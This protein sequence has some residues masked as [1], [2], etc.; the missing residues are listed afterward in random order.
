[1]SNPHPRFGRPMHCR[2][3]TDAEI[4]SQV[5]VK[6]IH[7]VSRDPA[8]CFCPGAG[9]G[10]CP[11]P[12]PWSRAAPG[13]LPCQ[14]STARP[15]PRSV[16]VLLSFGSAVRLRRLLPIPGAV[17]SRQTEQPP[18]V[19]ETCRNLQS[20]ELFKISKYRI[21]G[22]IY[23]FRRSAPAAA[24]HRSGSGSVYPFPTSTTKPARRQQIFYL[25]Y[26][27]IYAGR[28]CRPGR[29][30]PAPRGNRR[31]YGIYITSNLRYSL[32]D[33]FNSCRIYVS[34]SQVTT[35]T[36]THSLTPVP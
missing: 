3:A 33:Y 35:P 32:L 6:Y 12:A 27:I 5:A 4:C 34:F 23:Y 31:K 13:P 30:A 16:L 19:L 2:C 22:I 36:L 24:R 20:H 11:N 15:A 28:P 26:Q 18:K 1:M 10:C 9:V 29:S 7:G 17:R 21:I 8:P 25:W 14:L